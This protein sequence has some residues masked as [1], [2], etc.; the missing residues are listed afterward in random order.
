MEEEVMSEKRPIIST[1]GCGPAAGGARRTLPMP[2]RYA[3]NAIVVL[4]LLLGGLQ[5]FCLGI[6]GEY[7]SKIYVQVKNRPVYILKNHLGAEKEKNKDE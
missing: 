2:A 6:L 5:L 7:I 1:G 3:I 4:V